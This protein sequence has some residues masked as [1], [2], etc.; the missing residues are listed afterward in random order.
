MN[1]II[2]V[3]DV[4]RRRPA[5]PPRKT[6]PGSL[7]LAPIGLDRGGS[8]N[9]PSFLP[10]GQKA[11]KS[12]GSSPWFLESSASLGPRNGSI[13]RR[14][15][16]RTA[17]PLLRNWI[18]S[19]GGRLLPR[20]SFPKLP[21]PLLAVGGGSL[22]LLALLGLLLGSALSPAFPLPATDLLQP[23]GGGEEALLGYLFPEYA[24]ESEEGE[25][26]PPPQTLEVTTYKV[27]P[28]D[29]LGSIA[30]RFGLTMDS[31]VSLNR[32]TN[33]KNLRS[34]TEL[35]IPSMDGLLHLVGK[36]E[37]LATIG[38]R[39]G[40]SLSAIA[41]ANDLGSATIT[42]GQSLFIP[43]AS[44]PQ[45]ELRKVLGDFIAWPLKG[46]LSS[47]FGYRENPFSG[48]RQFH[49]GIDIVVPQGSPVRAVMEGRV[50]EAA[51][52]SIFGNYVILSHADGYQSLYGHLSASAVR[53]G[54]SLSQGE[55]LGSSGNTGYSTGP[56]L[57][58]GLYRK[59]AALNPLSYLK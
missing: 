3:Q 17:R 34:G 12:P 36:G 37:N 57:H 44:L 11:G 42:V 32:I 22:L 29:S 15:L 19:L 14:R 24:A 9:R 40:T 55:L 13:E 10:G 8:A 23:D 27:R 43:G 59:G 54:Q 51:Y 4:K 46:P 26:P 33:A 58:F 28:G 49:A 2:A 30:R 31:L 18:R 38:K 6:G 45:S 35:R 20:L 56:H 1:R 47:R 48:I 5:A 41:D 39:Y 50:A 25:L 52:S 7:P 53:K 21:L 16:G